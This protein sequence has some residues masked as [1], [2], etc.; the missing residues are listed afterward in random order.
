MQQREKCSGEVSGDVRVRPDHSDVY[1]DY[2]FGRASWTLLETSHR[3]LF[4]EALQLTAWLA[5]FRP[6]PI[7][8]DCDF[9][10][11]GHEGRWVMA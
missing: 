1:T 2:P 4:Q 10:P 5:P 11:D 7:S 3:F 8:I 6:L 9:I